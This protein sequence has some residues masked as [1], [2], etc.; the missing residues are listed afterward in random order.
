MARKAHRI[1]LLDPSGTTPAGSFLEL[2]AEEGVDFWP[3]VADAEAAGEAPDQIVEGKEY[4]FA[5]PEGLSFAGAD[6]EPVV[7]K[8]SVHGSEGTIRTGNYVGRFVREV[9]RGDGKPAGRIELE[10]RSEKMEYRT[11]YRTMLRDIEERAAELVMSKSRFAQQGFRPDASEPARTLYERFAF[12]K[13]LVDGENFDLAVARIVSSPLL[14][15]VEETEVSSIR[16]PGRITG[17]MARQLASGGNRIAVPEDSPLRSVAESLPS[18]IRRARLRD[19]ADIPENRFVKH[20]LKEFRDFAVDMEAR[21]AAS[22]D[23]EALRREACALAEALDG[24]L[25]D[26]FF[27]ELAPLQSIPL[28]SP[29]L[30]RKEGYREVL[31]A[32]LFFDAAAGLTWSGGDDVYAGGKRDIARLYEYWL[33]FKMLDWV[34]EAFGLPH[35]GGLEDL[36]QEAPGS[37]CLELLLKSGRH[38]AIDGVSRLGPRPIHVKFSYNRTFGRRNGLGTAGSWSLRMRPDY[39]LSLWPE[40]LGSELVA[41]EQELAVHVHFDAKYRKST[42]REILGGGDPD[43]EDADWESLSEPEKEEQAKLDNGRREEEEGGLC[44]RIDLLKMHAY[45]DAIRRTCGSYV[46]YPGSATDQKAPLRRYHEIIPGLGAFC[47]RPPDGKTGEDGSAPAVLEFLR[48]IQAEMQ[49]RTTQR[50]RDAVHR[51]AILNYGTGLGL[52]KES[53]PIALPEWSDEERTKPL[54]P[55]DTKV[56][57]AVYKSKEH[58]DWILHRMEYNFRLD[59][60]RGSLDSLAGAMAARYLLLHGEDTRRRTWWIFQLRQPPKIVSKAEL[61]RT[62]YPEPA[63]DRYL[64]FSLLNVEGALGDCFF[65][66]ER[67]APPADS[68]DANLPRNTTLDVLLAARVV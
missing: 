51:R 5:L 15:R 13:A 26:P 45:N 32:W 40:D 67:I 2:W 53:A 66:P 29:A 46:L 47:V 56:L 9:V 27:R 48:D 63:H 16:R 33:F 52:A 65:D 60:G 12:V 49:K 17:G 20:V 57:V 14:G 35:S 38:C 24:R 28:S 1:E 37:G 6:G 44:K 41:E 55:A 50:E 64:L 30:Q 61:E 54:V 34:G 22:K 10:V 19:T 42:I 62:G 23:G 11:H 58:L 7:R 43:R 18:G 21:G 68:A 4:E 25:S 8:S 39:T 31:R 59:S 36:L 3:N